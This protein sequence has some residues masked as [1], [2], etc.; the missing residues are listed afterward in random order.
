MVWRDYEIHHRDPDRS[1]VILEAVQPLSNAVRTAVDRLYFVPHWLHG[2]HIRVC[3]DAP[4]AVHRCVVRPAVDRV[5]RP[6]LET[7]P[8]QSVVEESTLIAS[9]RRLAELEYEAGPLLPIEPDGVIRERA[10]DDRRHV[11]GSI[12]AAQLL[13]DFYSGTDEFAFELIDQAPDARRRL[14]LAFELMIATAHRSSG[15]GLRRG[16]VS[17]RSH[18]EA[19]LSWW[20]EADGLRAR[21]NQHFAAHADLLIRKMEDVLARVDGDAPS[22]LPSPVAEDPVRRWPRLLDPVL[23]RGAGLLRSGAMSMDPPWAGQ[24]SLDDKKVAWLAARSPWHNRPRPSAEPVDQVWFGRYKLALNYTY[25]QLTRVGVTPVERFL[26]CHLIANAVEARWG[27]DAAEV[28]L[29]TS[30]ELAETAP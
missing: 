6:W 10:H 23:E 30:S 17:F 16:F 27:V 12:S 4:I 25:L 15:V 1:Q 24:T 18:A 19:F 2:S 26:L 28:V 29:P 22:R 14:L 11:L 7:H 21:W 20:P 5:V 3:V 9:H 8:F 13:S